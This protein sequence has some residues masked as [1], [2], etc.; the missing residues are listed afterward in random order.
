MNKINL[1]SRI[2]HRSL[3]IHSALSLQNHMAQEIESTECPSFRTCLGSRHNP[4]LCKPSIP[5]SFHFPSTATPYPQYFVS[6]TIFQSGLGDQGRKLSL[7][8]QTLKS[9][10]YAYSSR[11]I[12]KILGF[13]KVC[14]KVLCFCILQQCIPSR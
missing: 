4:T 6:R 7:S 13:Q 8:P 12:P 1:C 11:Q 5:L 14:Q 2:T 3:K 9:F 10:F